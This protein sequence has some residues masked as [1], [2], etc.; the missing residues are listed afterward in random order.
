MTAT[1]Q[2]WA[3]GG[4]G[5]LGM[6]LAH[7]L[8]GQGKQVTLYEGAE[9][10]GGLACAWDLGGVVW[11]RHY[12]V[13]LLSDSHLRGLLA[14]LGLA[15]E[16]VWKETRTGFYTDGQLYSMSNTL[17]FLRFP[18]LGL[19]DKLRL[20]FTIFYASKIRNWKRLERISVEAWLRRW[21]GRRT[22]EKIW[23]PLLRAKL[24]E[25]YR[26]ASAAFIWAIIARMY[27]ARRTGLKKEM[28]GYVRGGY[29][30]I[31]E[32]FAA[33][34]EQDGVTLRLGTRVKSVTHE[35]GRTWVE[36]ERGDRQSF[37]GVVVTTPAPVVER[38]VPGLSAGEK[39]L[40]R[41]IQYQGIV[42]ASLLLK[43]PLAGYYVTNITDEV[44]FTAVI[45][46]SALVDR[47]EFGGNSL[48]YLPRYVPPD[49][50]AFGW[51]DDEVR[52]KFL[53]AL[54]RMYPHFHPEDV[55]AFR[56]SRVR[57]VLAVST[58]NYS[59]RLPPMTTSV[60][61]LTVVNSA[62]IVN[63]TLNVN[64]TLALAERAADMLAGVGQGSPLP[65][66]GTSQ[67]GDVSASRKA[68]Q[69]MER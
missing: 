39:E 53:A 51:T 45:E 55:L 18:P 4:G 48:V 54:G 5:V 68:P 33:R 20:G 61:G 41:G 12:H 13:I 47:E 2:H 21:S 31:L 38:M 24:G 15:N 52:E 23:L 69:L 11:D 32:R 58:L 16:L 66:E 10:L 64:E 34:L 42:C 27:A 62:H 29:A 25:N 44:P 49:D 36:T 30:R 7:R 60:P 57:H 56:V 9:Q 6:M 46:T 65:Q 67:N 43:Q 17:E 22:F 35:E 28:F 1:T 14:E 59:E 26:K 37:D 3:V 50:P 19:I 40:M 63:G 8:S